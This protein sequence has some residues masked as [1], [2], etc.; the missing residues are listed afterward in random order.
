MTARTATAGQK[1]QKRTAGE[2]G[3][4]KRTKRKRPPGTPAGAAEG[5]GRRVSRSIEEAPVSGGP[6]RCAE[7]GGARDDPYGRIDEKEGLKTKSDETV[8][9][10]EDG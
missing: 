7:R 9:K 6:G 8:R 10:R 3:R 2:T 4:Q 5:V 1:R